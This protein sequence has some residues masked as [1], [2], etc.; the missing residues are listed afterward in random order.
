MLIAV[1]EN[2]RIKFDDKMLSWPPGVRKTDGIWGKHWYKQVE[3]SIGFKPYTKTDRIIP[4][5]YINLNDECM[6]YY[7]FLYQNRIILS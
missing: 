7:D 5:E 6:Q 4:H 3:A 2:L 1:C